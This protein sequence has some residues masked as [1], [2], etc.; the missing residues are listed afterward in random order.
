MA[1]N[2]YA[3][4]ARGNRRRSPRPIWQREWWNPTS[5]PVRAIA[6][7][8]AGTGQVAKLLWGN[9]RT[10]SVVAQGVHITTRSEVNLSFFPGETGIW[11]E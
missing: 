2:L 7:L 6:P 10:M 4:E 1:D 11:K 3:R 5:A 8:W 9:G